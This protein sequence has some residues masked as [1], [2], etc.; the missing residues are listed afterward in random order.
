MRFS[1]HNWMRPEP[2]EITVERL[3]RYGYDAI[4]IMGEPYKYDVK[5]VRQILKKHGIVC[6]GSVSIMLQDRD[7][8]HADKNQREESVQY[9]I[10]T[11][12]MIEGLGGEV[13]CLVPAEVSR[14]VP[15]GAAE[16]C[17]QRAVESLKRI[18]DVARKC[19]VKIGLEPLNRFETCFLNHHDQAVAL[20]EAVGDDVG[21]TLDTFHMNIEEDCPFDAIKATG[22]KLFDFH[23]AD[24]NRRPPGQGQVDF[25]G[26]IKALKSAGYDG[27]VTSEFVNPV[28]RTPVGRRPTVWNTEIPEIPG[29]P[30]EQLKFIVDHGSGVL[31]QE[32]YDLA[33]K[34]TIEYLKS[35][36]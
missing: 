26:I 1:M 30:P 8:T 31:T 19:K 5:E 27:W 22:A 21:V 12:K 9:L 24:S 25:P 29:T 17:W 13:L 14:V 7:L 11:L 36:L 35:L 23:V 32:D 20:V 2:L 34:Q 18:A 16:D 15:H 3:A 10:D 6:S 4:E 28:D 33:V